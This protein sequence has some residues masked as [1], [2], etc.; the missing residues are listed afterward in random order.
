MPKERL[1]GEEPDRCAAALPLGGTSASAGPGHSDYRV[2][3]EAVAD[4]GRAMSKENVE[5]VVAGLERWS[6]GDETGALESLAPDVEFH[7]NVG[8]GTPLEGIYRGHAG[9]QQ[10]W[11][12]IRESFSEARFE[13]ESASEHDGLVL[14]LGTLRL[15]G[16][17]SGAV[18][19]TPFGLVT[20][21]KHGVGKQQ[22]LWTGDQAR[23]LEAVGLQG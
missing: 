3:R 12:D 18:A 1:G 13:V 14:V 17:G 23:A 8:L 9:V 7:H 11:A 2:G 10:L 15:R 4:T 6:S 19:D 22:F 21:V 5:L 16:S 20:E